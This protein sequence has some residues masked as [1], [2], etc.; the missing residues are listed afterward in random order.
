MVPSVCPAEPQRFKDTEPKAPQAAQAVGTKTAGMTEESL[1]DEEEYWEMIRLIETIVTKKED[2]MCMRSCEGT[3]A[4]V[5]G[6]VC[7]SLSVTE[8]LWQCIAFM[9]DFR[10]SF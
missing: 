10:H 4:V 2:G 8:T 1:K 7:C 9:D 6:G 5:R 3:C